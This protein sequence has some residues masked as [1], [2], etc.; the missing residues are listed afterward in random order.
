MVTTI[1]IVMITIVTPPPPPL[2]RLESEWSLFFARVGGR[3]RRGIIARGGT[4]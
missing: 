1:M 4:A 3:G 2:F